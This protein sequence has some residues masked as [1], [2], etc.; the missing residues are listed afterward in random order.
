MKTVKK[1]TKPLD[2]QTA[3]YSEREA[4]LQ[5]NTDW[6]EI[7]R[8]Q[9]LETFQL[10]STRVPAYQKFLAQHKIRPET[11][12]T[13]QD[14]EQLPLTSK[15]NYVM[16]FPF[17]ERCIDGDPTVGNIIS[18]SS[19]STGQPQF[20]LRD[21][22]TNR[23]VEWIFELMLRRSFQAHEK[24]TLLLMAF[25]LG[26]WTA[27]TATL[28]AASALAGAGY[29]LAVI[30]PGVDRPN[31]MRAIEELSPLYDQTIICCYPPF[32]K[33]LIDEGQAAGID[34]KSRNVK[35]LWGG[36]GVS[37]P[38]RDYVLEKVGQQNPLLS[39]FNFLGSADGV[40]LGFET[41]AAIAL[42]RIAHRDPGFSQEL[43]ATER[44]PW[45][46]QYNPLSKYFETLDGELVLTGRAAMPL[47]RYNIHDQGG[48]LPRKTIDAFLS[49]K[50]ISLHSELAE[51][52]AADLDTSLPFIYLFGRPHNNA[53][54]Y[55]VN[56]YPENIKSVLEDTELR[57]QFSG[58][59]K[60]S[61][62]LTDDMDQ[63]LL[64][65][66]ELGRHIEGTARLEERL[67]ELIKITVA[68]ANSEYRTLLATIG[69]RAIPRVELL[70]FGDPLFIPGGIKFSTAIKKK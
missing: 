47:I 43:F 54:L 4:L 46:Y 5:K 41:P 16:K 1:I 57:E 65:R 32:G 66:F 10:A 64:L 24:K 31:I 33:D 49:K 45:V 51:N 50:R 17:A 20:W 19:G 67:I 34:W 22:Q 63:Y 11:I 48:V 2:A 25:A 39:T 38:W 53:T 12:K 14:F 30:S 35:F 7:G 29:P 15:E 60:M 42:K 68:S 69:E 27:G 37:E 8:K 21:Q 52:A 26:T 3:L 18:T 44:L 23:E 55:G 9:A 36:E 70:P 28:G 59:F 40:D 62:E 58:R 13:F 6:E 56:I 61:T